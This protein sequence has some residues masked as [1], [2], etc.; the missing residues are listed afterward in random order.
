MFN[1]G[2]DREDL[3]AHVRSTRIFTLY[4]ELD[5]PLSS[6]KYEAKW[7]HAPFGFANHL[8]LILSFIS[9]GKCVWREKYI[10]KACLPYKNVVSNLT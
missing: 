2:Y 10:A 8:I 3:Y 5:I 4:H 7:L 1:S 9:Y 6:K